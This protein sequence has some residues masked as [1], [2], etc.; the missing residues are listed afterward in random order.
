M[1]ARVLSVFMLV[2]GLALLITLAAIAKEPE[3]NS[4][5][6]DGGVLSAVP[7][8]VSG[9]D[10]K[11]NV[12]QI[13]D[14]TAFTHTWWSGG[15]VGAAVNAIA[16]DP[17]ISRTVYVATGGGGLYRSTDG[18]DTWDDAANDPDQGLNLGQGHG[19]VR[20]VATAEG[21]VYAATT[22]CEW[23]HW[24]TDGGDTWSHASGGPW[25][26]EDLAVHPTVTTNLYVAGD[27]VYISTNGGQSWFSSSTGIDP[28][29]WIRDLAI[30]PIT[31]T[32][33][34]AASDGKVYKTA[35][36]GAHWSNSGSGLP[37]QIVWSIAVNPLTPTIVYAGL[38]AEGVWRSD[39]GGA[40]WSQWSGSDIHCPYVREIVID[41]SDP[42]TVYIGT[43]GTGVYKRTEGDAFWTHLGPFYSTGQRRVYAIGMTAN[44]PGTV[45]AGVWGDGI[46]KSTDGG[47]NWQARNVNLSA[48]HIN[49]IAADPNHPGIAYA[50]ARGG[51]F[52]TIDG[53]ETWERIRDTGTWLYSDAYA[54]AIEGN[55]GTIY[56]GMHASIIK[57]TDG[58][59]WYDASSGLPAAHVWDIAI[60]PITPTTVY[61]AQRWG[62]TSEIGVY[63][64]KNGGANWARASSGITDTN[65]TAIA[66][67]P[68]DPRI[69][70]AGTE[71]GNVFRS[72]NGG[73]SWSWSGN[74]LV[75]HSGWPTIWDIMPDPQAAGVVYLAQSNDGVSGQGGIYK[76]TDYGVTWERAL[77][78]H[79]P[80]ALVID[81]LNHEVLITASWNDYLYRSED[82][83]DTWSVYDA[84]AFTGYRYVQ[85]LAVGPTES[86][87][88]RLY[89]G[90]GTNS[91]WQRD[92]YTAVFLPLVLKNH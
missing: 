24:S 27:D 55:T 18:G 29:D 58:T 23:F 77:E 56:V 71:Q 72:T 31:P 49:R 5:S 50:T 20:D 62:N 92:I 17:V 82:A 19:R 16:F 63:R 34:Y 2:V 69:V 15:P 54:L 75:I 74:G 21:V 37:S 83:G 76:S 81:P 9:R 40:N 44:A 52:R 8:S 53:G 90:T 28:N 78:G 51:L 73:D 32:I 60:N 38:E 66:V 65:V 22:G 47:Q 68:S 70:Y 3:P 42:N 14:M 86:G 6:T 33:I 91:I 61:A 88:W 57:T 67:D 39:D 64:S 1:K 7:D 48:L 4:F 36:G 84:D 45:F 85:A 30:N 59:N 43:D 80:R 41:P 10:T 87:G 12:T 46:Y 13:H 79:D 35:D 11:D 89:A 25:W 26:V